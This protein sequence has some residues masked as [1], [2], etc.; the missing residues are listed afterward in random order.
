MKRKLIITGIAIAI[1][2][3]NFAF[4]SIDL[5]YITGKVTP[6]ESVTAVWAIKGKDSVKALLENGTFALSVQPGT[7]K[8]LIDAVDPYKDVVRKKITVSEKKPKDLGEI[9]L[10]K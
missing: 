3:C 9:K 5:V 6:A 7:Y 4:R 8:V 10:R 1:I 2:T